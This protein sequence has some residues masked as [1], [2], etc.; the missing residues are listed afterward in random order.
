MSIED[1]MRLATACVQKGDYTRTFI[2]VT[3]SLV[4][5]V[6]RY[7]GHGALDTGDTGR[8]QNSQYGLVRSQPGRCGQGA[9]Q[10]P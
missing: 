8:K 4:F 3:R 7:Y 2:I 6:T 5:T 10:Y 1:L 9:T